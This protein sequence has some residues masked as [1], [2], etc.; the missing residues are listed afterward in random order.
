MK[1]NKKIKLTIKTIN[2]PSEEQARKLVEHISEFLRVKY[3]S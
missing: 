2:P 1:K 3:Y